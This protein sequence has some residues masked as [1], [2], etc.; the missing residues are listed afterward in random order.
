MHKNLPEPRRVH[1]DSL[2]HRLHLHDADHLYALKN[3]LN[4]TLSAAGNFINKIDA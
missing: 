1:F 4:S 2:V 3:K